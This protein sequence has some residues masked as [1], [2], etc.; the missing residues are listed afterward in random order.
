MV[1]WCSP[2]CWAGLQDWS[3]QKCGV[4]APFLSFLSHKLPP[5]RARAKPLIKSR[6][7]VA[8][9]ELG[10]PCFRPGLL[11]VSRRF[12]NNTA[13]FSCVRVEPCDIYSDQV[14][15]TFIVSFN[16]I[17]S[18]W[19]AQPGRRRVPAGFWTRHYSCNFLD[20]HCCRLHHHLRFVH[21]FAGVIRIVSTA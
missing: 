21:A 11:D 10:F 14:Y 20:W 18:K 16:T 13:L 2:Y 5:V 8:F 3:Y 7:A 9:P 6:A 4:F 15:I 19:W 1:E 17:S 12:H